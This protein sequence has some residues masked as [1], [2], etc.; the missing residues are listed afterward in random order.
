MRAL[1]LAA[2]AVEQ[3]AA[4]LEFLSH[5]GDGL[6][7]A[8]QAQGLRFELGCVT[9]IGSLVHGRTVVCWFVPGPG[10]YSTSPFQNTT[11]T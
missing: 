10:I 9:L 8:K 7:Q 6:S 2:P 1:R 5:V 3:V 4:D 11:T